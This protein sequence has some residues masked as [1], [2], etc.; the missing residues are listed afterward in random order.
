MD[1]KTY[2]T[3][4]FLYAI[5]VLFAGWLDNNMAF[6]FII[7]IPFYLIGMRRTFRHTRIDKRLN[8]GEYVFILGYFGSQLL[9]KDIVLIPFTGSEGT[10]NTALKASSFF[11]IFIELLYYCH[12]TTFKQEYNNWQIDFINLSQHK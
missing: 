2:R 7:T 9:M 3:R 8:M 11:N 6:M 4:H 5:K 10:T 1:R 12:L